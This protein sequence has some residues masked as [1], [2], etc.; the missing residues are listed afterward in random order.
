MDELSLNRLD[1]PYPF[2][3]AWQ[4]NRRSFV[5]D[6]AWGH[7]GLSFTHIVDTARE[8]DSYVLDRLHTP[9]EWLQWRPSNLL[10]GLPKKQLLNRL[11]FFAGAVGFDV[12]TNDETDL[13]SFEKDPS[14]RIFDASVGRDDFWI[15]FPN[16]ALA[17]VSLLFAMLS[18]RY[19]RPRI[20]KG[21]CAN[22]GYDLRA[23]PDRCPE[24][25]TAA[26]H[27]RALKLA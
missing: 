14:W 2:Q 15:I 22:C 19:L 20:G 8:R 27:Q 9:F 12:S 23:T 21:Q 5:V 18:Y 11:G 4:V 24:C 10:D 16:W 1:G 26:Q 17:L 3:G 6:S 25:G 13:R 7:I